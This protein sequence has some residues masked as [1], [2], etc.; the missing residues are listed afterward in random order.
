MTQD[1]SANPYQP[2]SSDV[3]D[4]DPAGEQQLVPAGK[5]RRFGTLI[6]DYAGYA[7]LS[8]CVGLA[9]AILDGGTGT[10]T[11]LQRHEFLFGIMIVFAYYTFF[12]GI[13]ARTPGKLIFGT[14]VIT[15]TGGKPTIGQVL[16]RTAC[17][18]IPFEALS[19]LGER[20]W[21]D[22]IPKTCVVLAK[23]R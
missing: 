4:M 20:G 17:R 2:P 1:A 7:A 23:G 18:F 15:E 16:G 3:S 14:R 9:L 12:E 21:H 6:V 13:W 5:G 10:A 22:K 19:C 11:L 8:F